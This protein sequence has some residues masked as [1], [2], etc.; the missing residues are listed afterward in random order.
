MT[1]DCHAFNVF[2]Y[3]GMDRALN[4]SIWIMWYVLYPG[5]LLA[6]YQTVCKLKIVTLLQID[7]TFGDIKNELK[8]ILVIHTCD[9]ITRFCVPVFITSKLSMVLFTILQDAIPTRSHNP[10]TIWGAQ[11][12]FSCFKSDSRH[13]LGLMAIFASK[14]NLKPC[15]KPLA[16]VPAVSFTPPS[17][18][19]PQ[20]H[21]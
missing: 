19:E 1:T 12:I 5:F 6:S 10:L 8:S 15:H 11:K 20:I 17:I 16:S 7:L 14:P 3:G 13:S 2:G 4:K 18:T 9:L 21:F